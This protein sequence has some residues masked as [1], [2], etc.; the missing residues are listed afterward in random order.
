MSTVSCCNTLRSILKT[1]HE[2]HLIKYDVIINDIKKYL[3]KYAHN[4]IIE[5]SKDIVDNDE[6]TNIGNDFY[7]IPVFVILETF[8]TNTT[9]GINTENICD[10]ID[11]YLKTYQPSCKLKEKYIMKQQLSSLYG[12]MGYIE[13]IEDGV[14][15]T[16]TIG[17]PK[18]KCICTSHAYPEQYDVM[19]TNTNKVCGYIRLRSGMLTCEYINADGSKSIIYSHEFVDHTKGWFENKGESA[20]YLDICVSAISKKEEEMLNK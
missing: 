8:D 15:E 13:D 14:Y 19:N 5:C 18:Y 9:I 16:N 11:W 7:V 17:N 1:Y 3:N 2:G 20:V 10:I 12:R 4:Y 6:I